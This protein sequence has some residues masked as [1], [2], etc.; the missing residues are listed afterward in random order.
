MEDYFAQPIEL[1]EK[2]V[3]PEWFYQG[4]S[5]FLSLHKLVSE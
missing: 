3:R 2:D 1:L 4:M 5:S